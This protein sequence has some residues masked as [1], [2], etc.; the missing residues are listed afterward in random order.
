VSDFWDIVVIYYI[1]QNT[2]MFKDKNKTIKFLSLWLPAMVWATVI[3]LFSNFPSIKTTD[4]FLSDFIFKKTAHLLEYGIL[5][6][7]VFRAL[8]G[9]Y[10][11]IKKAMI[12][13]ILISFL[14]AVSD[15]FH[16]SFIPGREPTIRDIII[17]TIGA[18]IGAVLWK[19]RK[20]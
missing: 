15:E 4:F 13:S 8:E 19:K 5:S 3:F 9:S 11:N 2:R 1:M 7:L 20:S 14:Y 16:Q 17:D 6:I 10:I 12:V 18:T